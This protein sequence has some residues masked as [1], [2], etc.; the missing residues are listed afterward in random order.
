MTLHKAKYRTFL[1]SGK[2]TIWR[3]LVIPNKGWRTMAAFTAFLQTRDEEE[4]LL[5]RTHF[6]LTLIQL[7]CR[8]LFAD[9][10]FAIPNFHR[11]TRVVV[12]QLCQ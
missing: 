6:Q 11:F 3:L 7:Y 2:A 1:L 5:F 9:F 4:N 10:F 12:L 8:I